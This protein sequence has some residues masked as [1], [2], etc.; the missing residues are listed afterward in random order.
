MSVAM[1]FFFCPFYTVVE[2]S[3]AKLTVMDDPECC[4]D[5]DAGVDDRGDDVCGRGLASSACPS[6]C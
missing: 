6:P 2:G 1:F 3:G 5:E 4:P